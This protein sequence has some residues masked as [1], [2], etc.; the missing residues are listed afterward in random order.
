MCLSFF[1][2][3]IIVTRAQRIT[4]QRISV[5]QENEFLSSADNFN[6]GKNRSSSY[7]SE[8]KKLEIEKFLNCAF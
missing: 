5:I 8:E 4:S 1:M 6:D 2:L 7:V 3:S